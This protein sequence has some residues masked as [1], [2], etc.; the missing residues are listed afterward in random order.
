MT[1]VHPENARS[2]KSSRKRG[3]NDKSSAQGAISETVIE[4]GLQ[5]LR[6]YFTQVGAQITVSV[7]Q[8][9]HEEDE[10]FTRPDECIFTL[11]GDLKPLK[12]NPQYVASLTKLT[13]IA[14]SSKGRQRY[15]CQLDL[16]GHL[17]ARRALLQV[18]ADDAAAVAKH[19][20]KRAIIEGLSAGERRQIHQQVS[21]D[22][23]VET[24]SDGE[25]EF[26]YLMVAIKT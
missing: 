12:R 6:D 3:S 15:L 5:F 14:M 10:L 24:L 21:E 26:R 2:V 9:S 20:H 4:L 11:S 18:I 17:T 1:D 8:S 16:D 22:Q 19:T 7:Y 13:T 25:D 23:E